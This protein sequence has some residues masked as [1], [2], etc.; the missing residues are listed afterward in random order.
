MISTIKSL[1]RRIQVQLNWVRD[2][3][4]APVVVEVDLD[5][6]VFLL[7]VTGE[8]ILDARVLRERDVRA[9]IE[10]EALVIRE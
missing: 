9:L 5:R 3:N 8:Q 4:A 7:N 1:G 10:Q 6:L 2:A